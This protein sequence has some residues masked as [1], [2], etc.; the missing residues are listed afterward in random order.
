[1]LVRAG[2]GAD[3]GCKHAHRVVQ[4]TGDPKSQPV[5]CHNPRLEMAYLLTRFIRQVLLRD[6]AAS[7]AAVNLILVPGT[8]AIFRR[9]GM[10]SAVGRCQTLDAA[11]DG[12]V[13]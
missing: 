7:V 1:M 2:R 10:L 3:C 8:G 6:R 12:Y 13:R 9:A 5:L 11:A 4:V